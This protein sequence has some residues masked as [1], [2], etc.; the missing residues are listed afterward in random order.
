[1]KVAFASTATALERTG[2]EA[3]GYRLAGDS[4]NKLCVV[5][6][7][8]RWRLLLA[9]PE[10]DVAVMVDIG[11]HLDHDP[12]RDVYTRLYEALGVDAPTEPRAKPSCCDEDGPP[13]D[14]AQ[15]DAF[16]SAYR[17]LSRRRRP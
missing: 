15:L 16:G 2:C 17:A 1:V 9:F 10:L 6:L 12:R 13:V 11:E 4:I 14:A 3:A 7:W 5:H 8:G